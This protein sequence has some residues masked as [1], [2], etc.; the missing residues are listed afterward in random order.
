[1]IKA[2]FAQVEVYLW[3]AMAVALLI[4]GI[5]LVHHIEM[6]GENKVKAADAKAEAA[7]VIHK[8][9]VEKRAQELN[10]ANDSQLHHTLVSPPAVPAIVVRVCPRAPAARAILPADGTP[11]SGSTGSGGLSSGVGSD[12]QGPGLDIAPDTEALL[13]R[14][15]A[16]LAYWQKF[17]A[18]CKAEGACK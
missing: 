4:G 14:A 10:S 7:R 16:K 2:W 9:E 18:T 8:E 6:I 15:N 11:V 1:M 12:G 3:A 17:Y 13:A 5:V